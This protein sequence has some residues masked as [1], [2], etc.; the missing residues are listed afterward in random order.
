VSALD[1]IAAVQAP[2]FP[3]NSRYA[4]TPTTTLELQDGRQIVYLRRR[5][6]PDP[7]D[8]QLLVEHRVL[9]A[10][11]RLDNL[12]AQVLGDPEQFWRICDANDEL[13]PMEL[14]RVGAV[15]RITLPEGIRGVLSA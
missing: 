10:S 2:R 14:L 13:D 3:A 4:A 9:D 11:E 5:F 6:R 15:V 7:S 8:L 12:A 1:P